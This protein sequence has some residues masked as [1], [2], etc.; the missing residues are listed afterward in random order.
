MRDVYQVIDGDELLLQVPT[1]VVGHKPI[2][3]NAVCTKPASD[4]CP[5]TGHRVYDLHGRIR[6]VEHS[7]TKELH[8]CA[9]FYII[10]DHHTKVISVD[11]TVPVLYSKVL[12]EDGSQRRISSNVKIVKTTVDDEAVMDMVYQ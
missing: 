4:M 6:A 12:N 9:E 1:S 8:Y 7:H 2:P 11:V 10:H 5:T 3:A